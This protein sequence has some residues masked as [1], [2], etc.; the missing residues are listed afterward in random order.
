MPPK[1]I[2]AFVSSAS[3]DKQSPHRGFDSGSPMDKGGHTGIS[4]HPLIYI[5]NLLCMRFM[6]GDDL[7]GHTCADAKTT[8][9][10][11]GTSSVILFLNEVQSS[12]ILSAKYAP[13]GEVNVQI[14]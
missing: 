8:D 14:Y 4:S 3:A 11:E 2:T 12:L 10:Q 6:R 5:K 13:N 9:V 7:P 1:A